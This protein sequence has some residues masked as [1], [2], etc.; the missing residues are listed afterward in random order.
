MSLSLPDLLALIGYLIIV[1]AIGLYFSRKNT[2]TEEYFVGGRSFSGWV[3]GLS[4]VGTSISSIT[5]LAYPGD[6]YKTAWLRYL[7]NLM[8][9]VAIFVAAYIFLPF[10]RRGNTI[11]AYEY[12]EDRFGPSIRVYGALTFI[13]GQLV[14]IS[15]ILYL[16]SLLI[17]EL[18]GL[19]PEM[20]I[21]IGGVFVAVYTIVGGIDAVI[22]TDVLQTI[23]LMLGGLFCLAVIIGSLPGGL[24]QILSVASEHGKL[25]FAELKGDELI[26]V[27]WSF[28]LQDKTG[29][30]LL[31]MGLT[32]WLT[33][34]SANQN[35]V[36]RFCASKSDAEARK[37]M[38][39]CAFTSLPIWAFYMFLGTAL[40]VFF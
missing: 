32:A 36:Q 25:A 2:S 37:A 5:F 40:Y 30:M 31:L 18:T 13:L 22:W 8:L 1:M 16:L 34:Y 29:T 27:D 39:V 4:L 33:E 15:I 24:E 21:I 28:S 26:P 3:I 23:V 17:H 7:P 11:T 6:A 9:P 19:S 12:L 10:F 20:S 35:T 14:R 38:F